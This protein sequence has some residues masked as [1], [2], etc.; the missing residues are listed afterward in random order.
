M[1]LVV[2]KNPSD[3]IGQCLG[4]SEAKT[5]AILAST[6]GK[7]LIIDEA[8]MLNHG[9]VESDSKGDSYKMAVID[10]LVAEV[11]SVPGDDRCILILGY[12][13]KLRDMFQN[14]NPGLSRR[15][16][17]DDPFLFQ[18]FDLSQLEEILKMKMGQQ[19]LSATEDAMKVALE[20]LGRARMRPNFSN[21]GEVNTC[22]DKAKLSC[23]ARQMKEPDRHKRACDAKLLPEDFDPDYKRTANAAS[24]CKEALRG[25]V[26]DNIIAQL[27][28]YQNLASAAR[29]FG[30]DPRAQV[31]TNFVFKG[32]PG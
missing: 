5:R 12:E 16:A 9:G 21:A 7:V 19:Q 28:E 29:K 32:P 14:V 8:Y 27:V 6:V 26:D 31:P 22:L 3:F 4:K 13:D 2:V 17:I 1:L 25:M 11:Q 18:D 10:T 30:I 20:V 23:Q 15:F 24:H